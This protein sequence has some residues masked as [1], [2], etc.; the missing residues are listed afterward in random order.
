LQYWVSEIES[1]RRISD[2]GKKEWKFEI[3]QMPKLDYAYPNLL[4]VDSKSF[5]NT[6][7]IDPITGGQYITIYG[8]NLKTEYFSLYFNSIP[9]PSFSASPSGTSLQVLAPSLPLVHTSSFVA[10]ITLQPTKISPH[11]APITITYFSLEVQE[12]SVECS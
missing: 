1:G 9:Q 6:T 5:I 2:F 11:T 7:D 12:V 10:Q 4:E 8:S 3:L